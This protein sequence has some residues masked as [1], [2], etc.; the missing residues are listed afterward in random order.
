M[1]KG[2]FYTIISN[3]GQPKAEPRAGWIYTTSRNTYGLD[4]RGDKTRPRWIITDLLTGYQCGGHYD[5]RNAALDFITRADDFISERHNAPEAATA[6]AIIAAAYKEQTPKAEQP[7]ALKYIIEVY[8][9]NGTPRASFRRAAATAPELDIPAAYIDDYKREIRKNNKPGKVVFEET[10]PARLA[11]LITG[12]E[13]TKADNTTTAPAEA[14]TEAQRAREEAILNDYIIEGRDPAKI[15]KLLDKTSN[16]AERFWDEVRNIAGNLSDHAQARY[17]VLAEALY[18]ARFT[19]PQEAPTSP[20][21]A[22]ADEEP[23]TDTERPTETNR[24]T[25]GDAAGADSETITTAGADTT[26]DPQTATETDG[27]TTGDQQTTNST[28]APQRAT[29]RATTTADRESTTDGRREPHRATQTATATAGAETRTA[30]A[31]SHRPTQDAPRL[32]THSPRGDPQPD[33]T[34]AEPNIR[35]IL[36]MTF[37]NR[38][39]KTGSPKQNQDLKKPRQLFDRVSASEVA[40]V[41]T[42]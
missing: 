21:E 24:A 10:A 33:G 26:G 7:P 32:D 39:I 40:G 37:F 29:E 35:T 18:K 42:V 22:A 3:G 13:E 15:K 14:P 20:A 12:Q 11:Y 5:T 34:N 6:R 41:V 27:T 31:D 8:E 1:K 25:T 16:N 2:S 9:A 30:G 17:M 4:N 19:A 28:K 36:T 23:T 38:H